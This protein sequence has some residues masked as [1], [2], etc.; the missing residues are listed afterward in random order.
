MEQ[1]TLEFLRLDPLIRELKSTLVHSLDSESRL[2]VSTQSAAA[3]V[4][5]EKG[6]V[7]GILLL[8]IRISRAHACSRQGILIET[9]QSRRPYGKPSVLL[10]VETYGPVEEDVKNDREVRAYLNDPATSESLRH[11]FN[12]MAV[13]SG[14]TLTEFAM[15]CGRF[16]MEVSYQMIQDLKSGSEYMAARLT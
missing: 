5:A 10:R 3:S 15:T 12:E 2:L 1:T 13:A 11:R 7:E 16:S 4:T 6:M 9:T 8:A 14:G